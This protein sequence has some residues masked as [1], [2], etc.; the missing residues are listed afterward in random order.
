V[1]ELVDSGLVNIVGGCCGTTPDHIR[2]IAEAV[3]GLPPRRPPG[4]RDH[5]MHLSGLETLTIRRDSNFQMIGERTNVTGSKKFARLVIAGDYAA[6]LEVALDQVRGGANI[7]DV[8][9][10][11]GML[12]SEKAMAHFLNLVATEPEIARVPIMVDSSKWSVIEAGLKCVQGKPIVNS[13]SLKEGEQVFLEHARTLRRHGA[14]A[15]IMAFDEQG[16]A[17]TVERRLSVCARAYRILTE[18]GGFPPEDIIFDPNIFAIATGIEEH[19]GYGVAFIEA[20]RRIKR[21]LPH[22]LVSGG[23]SNVSFSFRGNDAVREAMHSVFL[24]HAIAAGMDMGI[25]NAGQLGV[26]EQIEPQLRAACEDV[27][28]NRRADATERLLE[29]AARFK[30]EGGARRA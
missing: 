11:E 2:A 8:N 23:V 19:N 14:A 1:R 28:L 21:E 7:L 25:V 10:D 29:I 22:A 9:M 4:R 6:A 17:D 24:Y 20:T 16:Q 15:V 3:K 12:D 13:I 30:G 27:V 26:Y 18:R 5:H